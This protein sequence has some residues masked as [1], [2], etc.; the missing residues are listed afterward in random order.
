MEKQPAPC[1]F[2]R[3]GGLPVRIRY[4]AAETWITRMRPH[5]RTA[6]RALPLATLATLAALV[7]PVLAQDSDEVKLK[8]ALASFPHRLV[9]ESK[10]EGNVDVYVMN[11]DGSGVKN[12]TN[13]ADV[14][15]VN[16]KASP[17]GR[18]IAF[19]ADAT[20]EGRR[21]RDLYVMAADGSGRRKI[22]DDARDPCWSPD[23]RR[24][25]FL[26]SE[27]RRFSTST[28]ATRGLKVYDLESKKTVT[29][30][31]RD[32]SH[33]YSL[34]WTPDSKWFVATVMGGLG[35]R[36]GI[37]AI[38]ADGQ[39]V[40]RLR[41]E[42]CRPDISS[43]GKGII[44]GY[45]DYAIGFA[46]L[47]MTGDH[48]RVSSTRRLV[49]NRWKRGVRR[50]QTYH[51]DW[52][53]DDQFVAYSAGPKVRTRRMWGA[54]PQNPGEDAPGWDLAIADAKT[55]A[56]VQITADGKSN[57]EP[58]WLFVAPAKGDAK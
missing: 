39:D 30:P 54:M 10:R 49:Y 35:Y 57:K 42:G 15:E 45:G 48:P 26:P 19:A 12:L 33:V 6:R 46:D 1:R 17:D 13:T 22:A 7:V 20:E 43:D 9:F 31:N 56:A 47:D 38:E 23:A 55:G 32:I 11:A 50:K 41:L 14:N 29:H 25:A 53:P 58:D 4:P 16:P 28:W 36:S 3:T 37:L 52:S 44:W 8:K 40:H 18:M 5:D 34:T 51:A 2:D 27:Y 24:V 21:V